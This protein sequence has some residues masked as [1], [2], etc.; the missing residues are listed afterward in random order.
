MKTNFFLSFFFLSPFFS[1]LNILRRH[2]VLFERF[3]ESLECVISK[4]AKP[5]SFVSLP[6]QSLSITSYLLGNK[7]YKDLDDDSKA[8]AQ[9][10]PLEGETTAD[11]PQEETTVGPSQRETTA[12]APQEE[13]TANPSRIDILRRSG[14]EILSGDSRLSP[15]GREA[16]IGALRG[17]Q[18]IQRERRHENEALAR[19]GRAPSQGT[20]SQEDIETE[21]TPENH[22][23]QLAWLDAILDALDSLN[24]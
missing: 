22:R 6:L 11:A 1:L 21:N 24:D 13:T 14:E 2:R 9:K 15:E 19:E 23:Q 5:H 8:K 10:D 16:V 7:M 20:P 4:P 18:E 3:L 12:D 17:L